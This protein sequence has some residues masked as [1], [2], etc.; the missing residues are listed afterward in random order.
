MRRIHAAIALAILVVA[1]SA[2]K[3]ESGADEAAATASVSPAVPAQ[4]WELPTS[5]EAYCELFVTRLRGCTPLESEERT[6]AEE[7]QRCLEGRSTARA[8]GQWDDDERAALGACLVMPDCDDVSR[9]M[10]GS[11]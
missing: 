8:L 6:E 3:E 2:C 4:S 9:C 11:P 7:V 10:R 1:A 5:D